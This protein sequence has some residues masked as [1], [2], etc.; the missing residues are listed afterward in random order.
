MNELSENEQVKWKNSVWKKSKLS[1]S[2]RRVKRG[3]RKRGPKQR[4]KKHE[5]KSFTDGKTGHQN[6]CSERNTED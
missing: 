6:K 3:K 4:N 2:D 5:V 1:E